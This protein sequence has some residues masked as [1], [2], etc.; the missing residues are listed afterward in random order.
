MLL[1]RR[2]IDHGSRDGLLGLVTFRKVVLSALRRYDLS[3]RILR[4][5]ELNDST[6][7][8]KRT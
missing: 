8:A 2:N 1:G 5:D 4:D 3:L 7:T 6:V